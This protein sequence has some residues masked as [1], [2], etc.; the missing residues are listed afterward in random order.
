MFATHGRAAD[1]IAE[2]GWVLTVIA[3]A[4]TVVI[5]VLLL[6]A[7]LR[8][9]ADSPGE[10]ASDLSDRAATRWI[11]I[12]GAVLPALIIAG[13]FGYTLSIQSAVARP[14][15][16]AVTT[17]HVVGH[18]WW[19]D[20][21]YEDHGPASAV[22]TANE[23]HLP[24][25]VPVRVELDAHDVIHSLWVPQLAGKTDLIPG[26][27][28]VMWIEA[29]TPGTYRGECAEYCGAQHANMN[30]TVVAE[31]PA[32]FASWLAHQRAPAAAP[33]DSLAA[34]G[35]TV[36][37]RAGCPACHTVRGTPTA[38]E[39]G[40]DLTHLTT[41]QMLAAGLMTNTAG[42]LAGWVSNAP[43]LKPGI[44]MPV[45]RATA[46]ELRALLAYLET[47]Q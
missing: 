16:Q 1:R 9:R 30:L 2:L 19:W 15:A 18:R 47:L 28:N 31:S 42:N 13:S 10:T 38:G 5:A 4:V 33:R 17:I 36:F 3:S 39:E 26:Q 40:P 8:R 6:I 34:S 27:T 46:G 32:A 35:W 12:G 29:R 7:L 24:V 44:E 37:A 45:T 21:R 20:V 23:L 14:L 25:G 11:V 43:A 41:R 22:H